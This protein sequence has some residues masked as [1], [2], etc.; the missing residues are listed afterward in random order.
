MAILAVTI[1]PML[2]LR[3]RS[4][5]RALETKRMR[6]LRELARRELD[7]IAL[8]VRYG[9]GSG[10][11]EDWSDVRYEYKV[12]LYDFGAGA[13]TDPGGTEGGFDSGL[14]SEPG[15]AVYGED[16]PEDYGPMVMRHVELTLYYLAPDEAGEDQEQKYVVDTYLPLLLTEE[17][18]EQSQQKGQAPQ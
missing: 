16:N 7:V 5:N 1:I 11:F 13:G 12:T 8:N 18:Y 15:D 4:Y 2:L 14:G 6:V 17:Q 9:Q 3:E 10:Q